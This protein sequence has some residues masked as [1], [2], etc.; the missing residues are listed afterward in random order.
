MRLSDYR[1]KFVELISP[2]IPPI[3]E[4][5]ILAKFHPWV[6]WWV[7][8]LLNLKNYFFINPFGPVGTPASHLAQISFL[9]IGGISGPRTYELREFETIVGEPH[10]WGYV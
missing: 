2:W 7:K 3:N 1:L 4:K 6:I 9:F 5:E 8:E 10:L